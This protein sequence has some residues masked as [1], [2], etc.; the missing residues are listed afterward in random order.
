VAAAATL[1][2]IRGGLEAEPS[3]ITAVATMVMAGHRPTAATAVRMPETAQPEPA[4]TADG[5]ILEGLGGREVRTEEGPVV[6][7]PI[8]ILLE[9]EVVVAQ[10]IMVV[11][12]AVAIPILTMEAE[13]QGEALPT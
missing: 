12:E 2:G 8:M 9:E 3:V 1:T 4:V 11:A 13:A 6:T 10:G 7:V 5:A